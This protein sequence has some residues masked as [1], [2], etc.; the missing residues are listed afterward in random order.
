MI[1]GFRI[2]TVVAVGLLSTAALAANRQSGVKPKPTGI[3]ECDKYAAMVTACLPKM[4]EV[5]RVVV[6]LDLGMQQ[7]FL[8]DVVKLKGR[9]EAARQCAREIDE[10]VK[11]DLYGCYP[12]GAGAS[13]PVRVDKIQPTESS[14]TLTLSGSGPPDGELARLSIF[15]FVDGLKPIGSYRLAGWN[16]PVVLDTASALPIGRGAPPA[17]IRLEPRTEYC[18]VVES[19][20]DGRRREHRKGIF[21]TL[22]KR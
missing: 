7:Q 17:P 12:S 16:G 2:Q 6:E 15:R 19:E 11:E 21:T 14:V 18:F 13:V 20:R 4:C 8:P 5:D 1:M 22:P 3:S 10:A 9:Q